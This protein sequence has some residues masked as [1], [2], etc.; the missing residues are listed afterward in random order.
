MPLGGRMELEDLFGTADPDERRRWRRYQLPDGVMASVEALGR[1]YEVSVHDIS[2]G[3]AR[4]DA[5][6]DLPHLIGNDIR[7]LSDDPFGGTVRWHRE[8]SFGVEFDYSEAALL[9]V[10]LCLK[11]L[12]ERYDQQMG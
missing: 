1:R 4:F 10:S 12:V 2:L 3:G 7:I 9:F 6:E 8:R 11:P 5:D